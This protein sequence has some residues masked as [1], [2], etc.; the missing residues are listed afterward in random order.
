MEFLPAQLQTKFNSETLQ[1]LLNVAT[2]GLI[3]N[4]DFISFPRFPAFPN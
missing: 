3:C 1:E 2:K 4:R